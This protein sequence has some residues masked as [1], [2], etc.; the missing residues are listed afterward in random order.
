MIHAIE[1]FQGV[2]QENREDVVWKK[3][4]KTEQNIRKTLKRFSSLRITKQKESNLDGGLVKVH[5]YTK[6]KLK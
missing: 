6:K 2:T 4:P 3:I 5:Y 1:F